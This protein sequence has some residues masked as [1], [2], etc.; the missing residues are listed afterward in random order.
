MSKN[1]TRSAK[2]AAANQFRTFFRTNKQRPYWKEMQALRSTITIRELESVCCVVESNP[3]YPFPG[4][5]NT[6]PTS[7]AGVPN[8]RFRRLKPLTL[9][10]EA[11]IQIARLNFHEA[12]VV[13]ALKSLADINNTIKSHL[14]DHV[15]DK[16][17]EHKYEFGE[18]LVIMKKEL[19]S[20]FYRG[21]LNGLTRRYKTITTGYNNTAWAILCH[22]LYDQLDPAF[23]PLRALRHW[24]AWTRLRPARSEWY[25]RLIEDELARPPTSQADTAS[26]VL[27]ASGVSLIDLALTIWRLRANDNVSSSSYALL[28]ED[29]KAVL[30]SSFTDCALTIPHHYTAADAQLGDIQ[31]FRVAGFFSEFSRISNWRHNVASILFSAPRSTDEANIEWIPEASHGM[32][33][34]DTPCSDNKFA[35]ALTV[36]DALRHVDGEDRDSFDQLADK[37]ADTEQIE[38]YIPIEILEQLC[39]NDCI[40]GSLLLHFVLRELIYRRSRT[41]DNELERRLVFMTLFNGAS[42][43]TVVERIETISADHPNMAR[44]LASIS[45]R[46]F[47][48]RLFLLMSSVKDVIETRILLCRWLLKQDSVSKE[49]IAD[50]L[51]ALER[52]LAN[53]DARSD[54]DSTR[55]HVD[56][57]SL[58]EWFNETQQANVTRYTQ[59]VMSENRPHDP[60]WLA[61]LHPKNVDVRSEEDEEDFSAETQIGSEYIL[62]SIVDATLKAFARDKTFGLDANL[63][64]RIRHG[65][66]SGH[67]M[68]P[69]TRALNRMSDLADSHKDGITGSGDSG[70]QLTVQRFRT[71]MLSELDH[72]RKDIIQISSPSHPHGLIKATWNTAA[73][74]TYLDA[75]SAR[76][77]S[78]VMS[79][80]GQYDLFADIYSLCWDFLAPDL[81]QTRFYM[82]RTFLPFTQQHLY[83]LFNQNTTQAERVVSYSAMVDVL[84]TLQGRILEVCGWFIKPV[85]RQDKYSLRMLVD[86]ACSIVKE[87]D[88]KYQFREQIDVSSDILLNR[89]SFDVFGDA[90]FVL[91]GNA[92]RHGKADGIIQVSAE[93]IKDAEGLVLLLVKS[94]V[95]TPDD[96]DIALARI[97]TALEIKEKALERAAVEEGSSGL[98]KLVI[99]LKRVK[100]PLVLLAIL[101]NR[102][103][104]SFTFAATLPIEI[105]VTKERG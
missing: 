4:L 97:K 27:R 68:T 91:I 6:F 69:V 37:I 75:M 105:S 47:L 74:I 90:L 63:S 94:E 19:F 77:R 78:R 22:L 39:L 80:S 18:S 60:T 83:E 82:A 57:E 28:N 25:T 36:A 24:H 103:E 64:R 88:D 33:E 61:K 45:T 76:V 104:L 40:S 65:S 93:P 100:S 54:I 55:V 35:T 14:F 67:V 8:V 23:N 17:K 95:G 11:A 50:E 99:V 10:K 98:G 46:T 20:A 3:N 52:E 29:I 70:I 5:G 87:Y 48:E 66:L 34:R 71:F 49:S 58:R 59:T 26:L 32:P 56:E 101:P 96:F 31:L 102:S 7:A 79:Y 2:H 81:A 9:E 73:N 51:E 16:I 21:G 38:L 85:F 30:E 72:I 1:S 84:E 41:P 53:L 86:S 43:T 62:L 89:G 42:G 44:L 12:K 92:A 15:D 13:E